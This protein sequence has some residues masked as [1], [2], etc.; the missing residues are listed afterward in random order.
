LFR[1]LQTNGF[2]KFKRQLVTHSSVVLELS[3]ML[4]KTRLRVDGLGAVPGILFL[5][6]WFSL[7]LGYVPSVSSVCHC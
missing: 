5:D 2:F 7:L 6:H 3:R 4:M 1:H